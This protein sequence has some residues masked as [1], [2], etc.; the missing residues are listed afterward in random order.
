M[1]T[2]THQTAPTQY[3]SAN[4]TSKVMSAV[5]VGSC[6][7]AHRVVL[8][9]MTRLRAQPDQYSLGRFR[10]LGDRHPGFTG[11][12][13]GSGHPISVVTSRLDRAISP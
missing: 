6:K 9:P 4:F 5:K 11:I 1:T 8:A 2:Y 7:R 12:A 13:F 3:V 10:S